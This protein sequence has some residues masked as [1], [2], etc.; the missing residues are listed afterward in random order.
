MRVEAIGSEIKLF[1]NNINKALK[2][3]TNRPLVDHLDICTGDYDWLAAATIIKD[4]K[5]DTNL[6]ELIFLVNHNL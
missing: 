4:L 1:I 3:N 5:F 2:L 6:L